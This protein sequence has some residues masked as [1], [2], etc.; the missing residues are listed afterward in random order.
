[1]TK[2]RSKIMKIAIV[3]FALA[4]LATVALVVTCCKPKT[5]AGSN[6]TV[7]FETNGGESI[8]P[9]AVKSG[10]KY[11]LPTPKKT[12]RVFSGWY[13]DENFAEACGE[14]VTPT[15]SITVY[16][17]WSITLTFISLGGTGIEPIN[18]Y[19]G[20]A[21]GMLPASY[22]NGYNFSGWYYDS[23]F[24][25]KVNE[26]DVLTSPATVYALFTE[27][28]DSLKKIKSVKNASTVPEIEVITDVVLHNDNLSDYITLTS[29]GGENV[30]LRVK[31]SGEGKYVVEPNVRLDEG[32]M[33]SAVSLSK[34][35]KF[36]LVDGRDT[37]SADEVSIT[38]EKEQ[39]EIIE[40]KT[41]VHL[42]AANLAK[43]EENV[44]VYS[45]AGLEKDVNRVVV[46]TDKQIVE[47]SV[48]TIGETE[49]ETDEDY[50]CKVISVRRERLQ[51]VVGSEILEDEFLI[52]DVV[53]PN[54]D[55]IY[56]DV[57]VF[58]TKQAE[59]EGYVELSPETIAA[60]L[61]ANEGVVKLKNS[62]REA[63]T[64]SPT[65]LKY[66]EGLSENDKNELMATL[67]AFSFQKP[68]VKVDISG[69]ELSFEIELGGEIQ[70]KSFK[71]SVNVV[72]ANSTSI[73]YS[74]TICKSRLIT[75]NPLLWFYTNITVEL[76]NDF[77][78]GLQVTVEFADADD[79]EDIVGRIDISDE[80]EQILDANKD[81]Q[82]KLADAIAGS[83]LWD[84]EDSDLEY[85]DI[86]NIPLGQ[87][88]LFVP[89]VSL[90][91]D[92]NI[93]GSLGARAGLFV[94][95]SHHYVETTTLAN[96]ETDKG[97]KGK[98]VMYNE[99][100]FSRATTANE[101]EIAI[102]LKGQVGFR[103]GLEAKLSL[104]VLKLNSVAAV[105]V[106]FRFG[107]YI[108]LSGLVSFRYAYDAVNKV[109]TTTLMGGMY[110]EV[111]LFVNAKLGAKFLVYDVNVD[112]FDKKIKLYGMG[113]R[114]IPLDFKDKSNSPDDPYVITRNYAGVSASSLDMIYLDI[115]TGEKVVDKANYNR[116]GA[117]FD[118]ELEFYDAP[119]YQTENYQDFVRFTGG[120]RL[121]VSKKYQL[122]SLK[123]AV[124][125][126]MLKK[127]GIISSGLETIVYV[128]YRN[129][130]GRDLVKKN[131]IFR[132]D[133]Y[134][135]GG[136]D[137][138]ED[139]ARLTFTEGEFV[140]PP[141]FTAE[142]L[143]IRQGYYLD[144]TDLWE[145]YY[146]HMG[147]KVDENWDGTFGKVKYEDI[148]NTYYRLKWK[149]D[150][151]TANFYAPEYVS[152]DMISGY[153][154]IG[155]YKM[156]Y[157]PVWSAFILEEA[158]D[159]KINAPEISGKKYE[160]FVSSS[161][162][163]FFSDYFL[164]D[165][166]ADAF[167]D[168]P[169][170]AGYRPIIRVDKSSAL[171]LG[172][173]EG[174]SGGADFYASYTDSSV[175]T[176]T[177]VLESESLKRVKVEY[178]PFD[179][180][181]KTMRPLP[182][183]D[184]NIGAEFE[185]NGKTYIIKGYRDINAENDAE[186][187][188]YS[189]DSMPD[190]TKNRIYYVL[191][192]RK[193]LSELPVYYVNIVA[194]GKKIGSYGVK[195][196]EKIN[197]ALIKV[198]Y[199]DKTVISGLIGYPRNLVDDVTKSY[200]VIWNDSNVP[201]EMPE[202]DITIELTATYAFT[203][204]KAEFVISEPLQS[205]ASGIYYETKENGER[206]YTATGRTWT[207]GGTD[208]DLFYF[209]PKL[210]DYFD[211]TAKKYYSFYGWKDTNGNEMPYGI[212]IAF[213]GNETY[214]P[215]FEEKQVL[216]TI[217]LKTYDDYGYEYYY[218]IL[219][220]DYFG[221]TLAEVL[222]AEK[223]TSPKRADVNG[224]KE[225]EFENWGVNAEKYVI[226]SEKDADG[227]VQTYILLRA[228]FKEKNMKHTVTF[229]AESGKFDNGE[230]TLEVTG[231]YGEDI[232]YVKA[233]DYENESGKFAFIGWTTVPYDKTTLVD[234]SD[235]TIGA[236]DVTY[237]AL[238][239]LAPA[240]ITLTF[241]GKV[242]TEA[243]DGSG[244]VY[245]N[246]N[247]NETELKVQ[248]L[249]GSSYYLTANLFAVD[250]KSKTFVPD[251]LK[252]TVDGKEYVSA[253]YNDGYMA[254]IPFD[255]N[256][257]VEIVFKPAVEKIVNVVF[258]SDG[259]VYE[260]DGT[261]IDGVICKG[262]MSGLK[263]VLTYN[264]AYGTTISA[265]LVDFYSDN[266]YVFDFWEGVIGN[267]DGTTEKITVKAGGKITFERD[268]VF[269]AVYVHDTTADVVLKFRSESYPFGKVPEEDLRGLEI[270]EG[271]SVELTNYGKAGEKITFDEIPHSAGKKFV[272]WTT[273]GK[274][275]VTAAEL[276]DMTYS[277]K[278]TY[279]AVYEDDAESF[280]VT[281][282]AG[283][284]SFG[285]KDTVTVSVPFGQETAKLQ[286]PTS[287]VK[288]LVFS[289]YEDENGYP[290][291]VI[292]KGVTLSAK[293]AKAIS[294][295]EDLRAA[296]NF[297]KENY[298]LT[299]NIVLNDI[300]DLMSRGT[301]WTAIGSGEEKGFSGTFNGN[302][303]KI[304]FAANGGNKDSFGL[305]SK[306]SGTVYNLVVHASFA[307]SGETDATSFGAICGEVTET[308]R[309]I[310]C[311]VMTGIEVSVKVKNNLYVSGAVGVN[312][313][314]I[315]GL[316]SS[317]RGQV[318]V[319]GN[320]ELFVGAVVGANY[321]TMRNIAQTGK[322][323]AIY[324]SLT[325]SLKCHIGALAG[326]NAGLIESSFSSRAININL[327]Q[328]DNVYYKNS[329]EIGG[330]A[331]RNEG[332]IVNCVT[333]YGIHEYDI[334]NV[335]LTQSGM[336]ISYYPY[337]EIPRYIA[338]EIGRD[339]QGITH[340]TKFV[341]YLD[342]NAVKTGS[343]EY[344]EYT[345]SEFKR[346]YPDLYEKIMGLKNSM[347][348]GEFTSVNNGTQTNCDVITE[349][350]TGNGDEIVAACNFDELKWN[351]L[352]RLHDK[353]YN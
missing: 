129:P 165:P 20:E 345:P 243:E 54:I 138:V 94:E 249:Y 207:F 240:T 162:L 212:G 268:I 200:E 206:V 321:G 316:H 14:S 252:W 285:G 301:D 310:D 278:E 322:G 22:K 82:D 236:A 176:E 269:N 8:T 148:T 262:Y 58:G 291:S 93:V 159:A 26:T 241:K 7:T 230:N 219:E 187:R 217:A 109:S 234:K 179:Y 145:K 245:F 233:A 64:N 23:G 266:Y 307:I 67:M 86:F 42:S 92:F 10:E 272:G 315:D 349:V 6:V 265:P 124:K 340:T 45:D 260:P 161:G 341:L 211:E 31:P 196:G 205:F 87:I 137:F 277:S 56:G 294:T 327:A 194:N 78:I 4:I 338:Y 324:V 2:Q 223:V 143:P 232:S 191:F 247:K 112:I 295:E 75:L 44:Y 210:N 297:P 248:G 181:G 1:M 195:Q 184:F 35:V 119:D 175:F 114:L 209:L 337:D 267:A 43:W 190:V 149:L 171:Y 180:Q 329:I 283:K 309:I 227:N 146:P 147:K 34:A 183:A 30:G 27:V 314:L 29:P 38:T 15:K 275:V 63:V 216:A 280:S 287:T 79:A 308:G 168:L 107:P 48:L 101:I 218:K 89:V 325:K 127:T 28:T 115:V 339:N 24:A 49:T 290:V 80:V 231:E 95:F 263:H 88:P 238:Y 222:S 304:S 292:E 104:S 74:Y 160:S 178:K 68:K 264:E 120:D 19:E 18:C 303:Y 350:G 274:D 225:Y 77:S 342:E 153:T 331:G 47:G 154:L 351:Y 257:T 174:I 229:S 110:L 106:S 271:G 189:A 142:T 150:S 296:V 155:S 53:T 156:I 319:D 16:A 344:D 289:H 188:Y 335:T 185:E 177:Y 21:I 72:I 84:E 226:G 347:L 163:S 214:T 140:V 170:T 250:S 39:R 9:A 134:A 76:A 91:I 346:A 242:S 282:K 276:K 202:R 32:I 256:A 69:T 167:R 118:Y 122:K 298:V 17:R 317:A 100:K 144:M 334:S 279:Y 186:S 136:S 299:N 286:K 59:L 113:D 273:D 141:Q 70:I 352:T 288:G 237:Y 66:A 323:G 300:L 126:K 204:L 333:A 52:L 258:V 348:F 85:V 220:G 57:D 306:V 215:V 213:V 336:G 166:E 37:E 270:F 208:D 239:S 164:V 61:E 103:C 81:G 51:Y 172:N 33:Y 192:E 83:P 193:G 244:N 41:T 97:P 158:K 73:E 169:V 343:T 281:L 12:E 123:F 60:N 130:D 125:V 105:Y 108:E 302:G 5:P 36:G 253:F 98:P 198:N 157:V 259:N 139:L 203:A 313:G 96:G 55:D 25:N 65:V 40:K 13:Y 133:Y 128:E 46:R 235:L 284:G 111:G 152:A 224:I 318:S 254:N 71:L 353:I 312:R 11:L 90:Q 102:T 135:G 328:G 228:N 173:F 50:I 99:F 182:P 116:Y 132:N 330:F 326:F 121:Y 221:K 199:D 131:S 117:T 293:Y 251:Y 311:A 197:L 201:T 246:G 320:N 305:F 62:V 261:I 3:V 332:E 151:Y 255:H